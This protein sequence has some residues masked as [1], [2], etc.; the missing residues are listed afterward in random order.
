MNVAIRTPRRRLTWIHTLK[1][2][3]VAIAVTAAAAAAVV[4][5]H[6]AFVTTE[7]NMQQLLVQGESDDAERTATLLG[8]KVDMLRDALKAAA[9]QAPADLWSDPEAMRRHLFTSE[10]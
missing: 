10:Q 1:S 9:R 8:T 4:T 6:F 2:Q 5:A 3:I 7:A